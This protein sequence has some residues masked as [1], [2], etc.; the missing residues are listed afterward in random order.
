MAIRST[1]DALRR[2]TGNTWDVGTTALNIVNSAFRVR[3]PDDQPKPT[4]VKTEGNDSP[5][6]LT[7]HRLL[8]I[9]IAPIA[10]I[11]VVVL[12]AN[13]FTS[14]NRALD[15]SQQEMANVVLNLSQRFDGELHRVAQ[16]AEQTAKTVMTLDALGEEQIYRLLEN[17]VLQDP[18][19]YGAAMGFVSGGFDERQAFCPYVYREGRLNQQ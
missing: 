11:L 14:T 1:A 12:G 15:E 17:G 8:T 19:I 7:R 10:A 5:K 18:L 6:T 9:T 3:Q 4:S 16:V 13:L 2:H